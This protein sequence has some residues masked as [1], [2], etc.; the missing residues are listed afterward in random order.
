MAW[1]VNFA[2][3]IA[4]TAAKLGIKSYELCESSTGYL[5]I[6]F[7]YTG[8][9]QAN[10]QTEQQTDEDLQDSIL[11]DL[12]DDISNDLTTDDSAKP[13]PATNA[14]AQ[15]V[16]TLAKPLLGKGHTIIMDNFYNSPLLARYLKSNNTDCFG[17]LRVIREFV[18]ESFKSVSK[19]EL[20][21]GEV[22][23]SYCEDLL[24]MMWRDTNVV[25][26][27]STFHDG[28]VGG[29]E[30]Y[31]HYKYKPQIVLEYN[32][33]MGGVDKKDQ[34]LFSH[35]ME[36]SRNKIWYKKVFRRLLNVFHLKR[37]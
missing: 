20:R 3:K 4:T 12:T 29:K 25:A 16:H 5:W 26:M 7:V 33:S 27:V 21:P 15:I 35:P 14:T 36:R 13:P 37:L 19:S 31:G 32:H 23:L 11:I 17:T 6:F 2:Q 24:I 22:M 1:Q 30:K 10:E 34:L 18:P 9:G 8:K 28:K